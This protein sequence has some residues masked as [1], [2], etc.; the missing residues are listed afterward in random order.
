M[1]EPLLP[2]TTEELRVLGVRARPAAFEVMDPQ[3]V[4]APGDLDF[5][6]DRERQA[7]ALRA[8]PQSRVVQ[9]HV[10]YLSRA[11]IRDNKSGAAS[12]ALERPRRAS[13]GSCSP[14]AECQ[15]AA[16]Q[17]ESDG[18]ARNRQ[19]AA[20][21]AHVCDTNPR[22][23]GVNPTTSALRSSRTRTTSPIT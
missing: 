6:V 5:V 18:D 1:P 8:I 20:P 22:T 10:R 3:V 9:E 19:T 16:S 21:D 2:D 13:S 7:L 14:S 17:I 12:R 23:G 4:Q 15:H 11:A